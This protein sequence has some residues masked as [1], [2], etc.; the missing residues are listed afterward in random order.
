MAARIT[1]VTIRWDSVPAA[2]AGWEIVIDGSIKTQAGQ[3]V[4]TS[5]VSVDNNTR[6]EVWDLPNRT[7]VQEIVLT[8]EAS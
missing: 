1:L 5:R 2:T 8:Q 6:I 7:T 3:K 4:R